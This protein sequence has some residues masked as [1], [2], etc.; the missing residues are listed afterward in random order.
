MTA[1]PANPRRTAVLFWVALA[2]WFAFLRAPSYADAFFDPDVA[3]TVYSARLLADGSCLYPDAVETKPPGSYAVL[4]LLLAIGRTMT[5]GLLLVAAMHLAVAAAIARA[6]SRSAGVAAG[7][8][9]AVAY[10]TY[11]ALGFVNGLAPNFE[12]W[13]VLPAALAALLLLPEGDAK[14]WRFAAAGAATGTAILMKQQ[15]LV[16]AAALGVAAVLLP[17]ARRG[18]RAER[19]ARYVAGFVV[20]GAIVLAAYAATGCLGGLWT[21]LGPTHGVSYVTAN[22]P[23]EV[24]AR[25]GEFFARFARHAAPLVAAAVVGVVALARGP[26]SPLQAVALLWLAG[27][28]GATCAGTM[29]FPHYATFLVA[30]LSV[31]A[32]IGLGLLVG[33]GRSRAARAGIAAAAVLV[34]VA[35]VHREARLASIAARNLATTGRVESRDLFQ[36]NAAYG[37]GWWHYA[38]GISHLELDLAAR[39]VGEYIRARSRPEE[40]VLVYDYVPAV[41]WYADRRAPT[42]HH[43]NFDVA[44]ELPANYGRWFTEANAALRANRA[45]LMRDLAARPPRYFVQARETEPASGERDDRNVYGDPTPYRLWRAP[46]FPELAA[47]VERNYRPADGAPEGPITVLERNDG[48]PRT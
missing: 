4:A 6:V 13:T 5:G 14:P 44:T 19:G 24:L 3:A 10:A 12:T 31:L 32:G 35:G 1:P 22:A 47:F 39:A 33:L 17:A 30:P 2:G 25:A 29:F 37:Y 43:M 27:A 20:P 34:L 21:A 8:L 16:V 48:P 7:R 9:A 11:S 36:V 40:T 41:Y 45:E 38:L 46:L 23:A 18:G 15:A 42:R 28:L 26:R